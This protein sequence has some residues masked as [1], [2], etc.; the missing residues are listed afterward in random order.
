[1]NGVL[2]YF[3]EQ[4]RSALSNNGQFPLI[5]QLVNVFSVCVVFW[6]VC[7]GAV[8]SSRVQVSA[9]VH[10]GECCWL[11]LQSSG[12]SVLD[13]EAG[14]LLHCALCGNCNHTPSQ[15]QPVT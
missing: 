8:L 5:K 12:R 10:S 7:R 15:S 3:L 4:E 13:W 1:M 11:R 2:F 14:E 6:T 9:G